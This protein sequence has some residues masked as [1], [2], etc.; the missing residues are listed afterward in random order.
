MLETYL[1]DVLDLNMDNMLEA[2]NRLYHFVQVR[3]IKYMRFILTIL[4]PTNIVNKIS[5]PRYRSLKH[6]G[7]NIN[8]EPGIPLDAGF[9]NFSNSLISNTT[10]GGGKW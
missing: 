7:T 9:Y 5:L 1:G 2:P 8:V 3:P 6:N 4:T 10:I